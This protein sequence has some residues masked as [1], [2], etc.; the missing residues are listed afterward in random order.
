MQRWLSR[1]YFG[2]EPSFWDWDG[3]RDDMFAKGDWNAELAALKAALEESSKASESAKAAK[4]TL[5]EK[6]TGLL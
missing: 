3:K 4:P 2:R 5:G 1:S 6:V